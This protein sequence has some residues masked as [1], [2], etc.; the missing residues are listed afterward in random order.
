MPIKIPQ[1]LNGERGLALAVIG[2]AARDLTSRNRILQQEARVWFRSDD[3][4]FWAKVA[5]L[6]AQLMPQNW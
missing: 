6:D 1:G 3:Y 4:F 2:V 5:G